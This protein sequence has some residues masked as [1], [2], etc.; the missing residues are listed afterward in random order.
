MLL[1]HKKG[2]DFFRSSFRIKDIRSRIILIHRIIGAQVITHL[3]PWAFLR[4]LKCLEDKDSGTPHK[5]NHSGR[6]ISTSPIPELVH[7]FKLRD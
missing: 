6:C 4:L 7:Y 3:S 1:S 5:R 2:V